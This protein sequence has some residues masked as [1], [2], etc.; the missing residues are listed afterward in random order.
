MMT[1]KT[2]KSRKCSSSTSLHPTVCASGGRRVRT[3]FIFP[4]LLV[5][6]STSPLPLHFS[7]PPFLFFLFSSQSCGSQE[8]LPCL[9]RPCSDSSVYPSVVHELQ[10]LHLPRFPFCAAVRRAARVALKVPLESVLYTYD[11]F[12]AACITASSGFFG[13]GFADCSHKA[14]ALLFAFVNTANGVP[15]KVVDTYHFPVKCSF[16]S[17]PYP[18]CRSPCCWSGI[19][20]VSN[21]F[22]VQKPSSVFFHWLECRELNPHN[23][24][25]NI[26]LLPR[27]YSYQLQGMRQRHSN[28]A[29]ACSP[30]LCMC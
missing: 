19:K 30:I 20:T 13:A 28:H 11:T 6:L 29:G 5:S 18:F 26:P 15:Q 27:V 22:C 7:L 16:C 4:L 14:R 12:H 23:L 3:R 9:C 17:H 2:S 8:H 21:I 25:H 1:E 24:L 10:P